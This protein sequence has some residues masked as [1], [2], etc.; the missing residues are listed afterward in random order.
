MSIPVPVSVYLGPSLNPYI[1][2]QS[3]LGNLGSFI[4]VWA[5]RVQSPS[6]CN[7]KM[8][9]KMKVSLTPFQTNSE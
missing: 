8:N 7:N 1:N 4:S 9:N 3:K 2:S 5:R 6:N